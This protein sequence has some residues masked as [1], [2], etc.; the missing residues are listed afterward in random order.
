MIV[1]RVT[2]WAIVFTRWW[3]TA[4]GLESPAG[5]IGVNIEKYSILNK[6]PNNTAMKA[7]GKTRTP[8]GNIGVNIEKYS[9]LN[10]QSNSAALTDVGK[11]ITPDMI[12]DGAPNCIT[13]SAARV[14]PDYE[15]MS[16]CPLVGMG[17][18]S[19]SVLTVAPYYGGGVRLPPLLG[20]HMRR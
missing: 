12:Y 5:D 6:Q 14:N 9:I 3:R 10:K 7:M 13:H 20:T 17:T 4:Q 15:G 18:L 11:T 19:R 16:K 2:Y 1:G 8:E